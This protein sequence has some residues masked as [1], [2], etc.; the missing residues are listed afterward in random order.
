MKCLVLI[1]VFSAFL[2]PLAIL[3]YGA[4]SLI[5]LKH[6]QDSDA[7]LLKN[8]QFDRTKNPIYF[9]H[10]SDLHI[11][12]INNKYKKNFE[13]AISIFNELNPNCIFITGDLT[14]SYSGHHRHCSTALNR[15]H[16]ELYRKIRDENVKNKSKL[17]E[18]VGNHDTWG[19]VSWD[20]YLGKDYLPKEAYAYAASRVVG[21]IRIVSYN[22]MV[23]PITRG[24][25]MN[26]WLTPEPLTLDALETELN[27]ETDAEYTVILMH[28][29][30][31][32][33]IP[34]LR[35]TLTYR[36]L[37]DILN[38]PKYKIIALITGHT[39]PKY[40]QFLKHEKFIECTLTALKKYRTFGLVT[41]DNGQVSYKTMLLDNPLDHYATVTFPIPDHL[42]IHTY[43]AD[44]LQVRFLSFT[45]SEKNYQITIESADKSV[46]YSPIKGN[47]K[48]TRKVSENAWLYTFDVSNKLPNGKHT[49]SISGDYKQTLNFTVGT[50]LKGEKHFKKKPFN[51][52]VFD[53]MIIAEIV[54]VL[55]STIP[56]F[57]SCSFF[58]FID[59]LNDWM[60]SGENH[61]FYNYILVLV[62][63]PLC[64][65]RRFKDDKTL[66]ILFLLHAISTFALPIKY[67]D[68]DGLPAKVWIYEYK[69]GDIYK[70]DVMARYYV[71][72]I[73]LL[74]LY[75]IMALTSLFKFHFPFTQI[76]ALIP[77]AGLE[78][79][80]FGVYWKFGYNVDPENWYK[81]PSFIFFP[82]LLSV[83]TIYKLM[84]TLVRRRKPRNIK[85]TD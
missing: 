30:T 77:F 7:K 49:L 25:M 18:I 12:T 59:N 83:V 4:L 42:A 37:D 29:P 23:P 26:Y 72:V 82:F 22:P 19:V 62:F 34:H 13:D 52:E 65:A 27:K 84:S 71:V 28:Q 47:L 8:F 54:L 21:N 10:I 11:T 45:D 38:D 57:I 3:A 55:I 33:Y 48:K 80:G 6:V 61:H 24:D 14:N 16:F 75:P 64:T 81:S 2:W 74:I 68:I 43:P 70:Q 32:M 58:S 41:I 40:T 69:I 46:S 36:T 67:Y 39:H 63:G 56:A 20:K 78:E 76:L 50:D 9:T 17:Y 1:R 35:S 44:D 73:L 85:K 79:Y 15:S 60:E 31:E 51:I 53:I 5:I 66:V